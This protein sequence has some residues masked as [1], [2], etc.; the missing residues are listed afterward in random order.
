MRIAQAAPGERV[1]ALAG[2]GNPASHGRDRGRG[3]PGSVTVCSLWRCQNQVVPPGSRT[4]QLPIW[5][6]SCWR[7]SRPPLVCRLCWLQQRGVG[8][9][10]LVA[11]TGEFA[12][13]ARADVICYATAI[14]ELIARRRDHFAARLLPAHA[15][16]SGLGPV[17]VVKM[18]MDTPS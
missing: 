11:I 17:P 1:L 7:H 10:T 6:S 14:C 16:A 15:D 4:S 5:P 13:V 12:R 3:M 2:D 9:R 8:A 18:G